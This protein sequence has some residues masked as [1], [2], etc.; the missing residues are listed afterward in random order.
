MRQNVI[1]AERGGYEL[2]FIPGGVFMMGSPEDEEGRFGDE[3]LHEVQVSDFYI[4][5]YPVTNEE[6]G[7]F[8]ADNPTMRE[9]E[10]WGSQ[11]YN[12]PNQP[13]VGVSG[14]EANA[15]GEWAGGLRLPTE[16]Q[17]EYACRAGTATRYYTGDSESDLDRAGWYCGNSGSEQHPVGEKEPNAFGLYDMH[18][19]TWEWC[20]DL[21]DF[22]WELQWHVVT[23][24]YTYKDGLVDPVCTIGSNRVIRGGACHVSAAHCRSA[25]RRGEGRSRRGLYLGFRLAA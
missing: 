15:Y 11:K 10:Y 13:V 21:C 9:P 20:L 12:Q 19:N 7:R 14:S 17:W 8:L 4:G 18:G 3:K 16:A 25:N 6:Y 5:R 22:D 23:I 2:V 24:T 1:Y